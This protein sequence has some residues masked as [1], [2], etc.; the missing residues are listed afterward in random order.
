MDECFDAEHNNI[1]HSENIH[2]A[3]GMDCEGD[4]QNYRQ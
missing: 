2:S 4:E 1:T 3:Y